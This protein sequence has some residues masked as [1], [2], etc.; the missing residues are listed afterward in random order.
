MKK[1][2]PSDDGGGGSGSEEEGSEH[3][4]ERRA[5][6]STATPAPAT[7]PFPRLFLFLL[8]R[9]VVLSFFLLMISFFAVIFLQARD[10]KR[11]FAVADP[12]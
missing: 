11:V 2:P 5:S 7:I 12:G 3:G 10:R 8:G 9:F 1:P 6:K 4:H